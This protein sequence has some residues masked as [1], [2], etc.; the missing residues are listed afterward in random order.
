M[1][2]ELGKLAKSGSSAKNQKTEEA[3]APPVQVDNRL[4]LTAKQKYNMLASWRGISR[5]M[6]STG[7][8]MFLKL[9]ES[10]SELLSLFEKFKGLKTKEEQANSQELIEHANNVM[11]TLDEGIKGLDNLDVLLEYLH[12]V[13]A[14]HRKIPGFKAEYFWKIEKPFLEA[15][16]TTLGDRYTENVENIYKITI[17]FIIETLIKGYN[18]A[19][20]TT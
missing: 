13:G 15:V 6:E 8:T 10:H 14:S 3:S 16:E 17:K 2:C 7:V 4:P 20:S 19:N 12:Q 5:A 1:G 18:N 9:F 11:N